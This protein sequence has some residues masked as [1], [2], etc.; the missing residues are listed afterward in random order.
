MKK[1]LVFIMILLLLF[2]GGCYDLLEIN[3]A[4]IVSGWGWDLL[5][6]GQLAL[7]VQIPLPIITQESGQGIS[8][9]TVTLAGTGASTVAA[10]R[11]IFLSFPRIFLYYH[12]DVMLIQEKLARQSLE[13]IADATARNRNI[14]GGT[15]FYV[16]QDST[17]VAD[18]FQAIPQ[19]AGCTAR[20]INDI[21]KVQEDLLGYYYPVTSLDLLQIS[22]VPGIE[23]VMPIIALEKKNNKDHIFLNGIAVFKGPKMIGQLNARESEGLHWLRS[24]NK[25]GGLITLEKPAPDIASASLLVHRF[26]TKIRPRMENGDL[27]MYIDVQCQLTFLGQEGTGNLLDE[28]MRK[29]MEQMSSREIQNQITSCIH[30]AQLLNSDIM[31][32]GLQVHRYLPDTWDNLGKDWDNIF[33]QISS[34]IH[35][36]STIR[37]AQL[38]SKSFTFK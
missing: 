11:N 16:V 5:D 9:D 28:K 31:G 7:V 14:R 32:F 37:T 27:S 19:F 20:C 8:P 2:T 15:R 1:S 36:E 3:D 34:K 18:V 21:I 25:Q 17:T 6:N 38:G 4:T 13:L 35:V 30:K 12:T 23:P 29:K 10:A 26:K 33:P 22:S 24:K